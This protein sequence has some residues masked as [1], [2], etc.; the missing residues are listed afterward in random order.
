MNFF[1]KKPA[2]PPPTGKGVKPPDPTPNRASE[3]GKGWSA[4]TNLAGASGLG[5][6]PPGED[7]A[8]TGVAGS[9]DRNDWAYGSPQTASPSGGPEAAPRDYGVF[10]NAAW[11]GGGVWENDGWNGSRERSREW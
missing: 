4:P 1:G 7:T 11:N 2:S 10:G 8:R 9:T 3:G 6:A 5:W